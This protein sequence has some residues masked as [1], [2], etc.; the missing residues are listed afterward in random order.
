MVDSVGWLVM[1][2]GVIVRDSIMDWFVVCH[3]EWRRCERCVMGGL[4][5][6][7]SMVRWLIVRDDGSVEIFFLWLFKRN[8]DV[9][10]IAMEG[11]CIVR[12]GGLG[13]SIMKDRLL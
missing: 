3:D 10:E 2:V 6:K 13:V 8:G 11:W 4:V 9:M 1:R 7:G 5:D 12:D